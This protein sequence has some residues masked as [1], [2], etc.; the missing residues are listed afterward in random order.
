[1][2]M[3]TVYLHYSSKILSKYNILRAGSLLEETARDDNSSSTCYPP[4]V[5]VY[6]SVSYSIGKAA[7]R[8]GVLSIT[9]ACNPDAC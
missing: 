2:K 1:M 7:S 8:T 6:L 9:F 5:F 3:Y 4:S